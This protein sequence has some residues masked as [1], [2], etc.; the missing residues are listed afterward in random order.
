MMSAM[1]QDTEMWILQ[2]REKDDLEG[3]EAWRGPR[4]S[5][6]VGAAQGVGRG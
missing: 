1:P 5:Q 4:R 2:G 3:T 6:E